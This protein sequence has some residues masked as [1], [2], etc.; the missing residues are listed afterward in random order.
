MVILHNDK[1]IK[2]T[3]ANIIDIFVYNNLD[4]IVQ[5]YDHFGFLIYNITIQFTGNIYPL[6]EIKFDTMNEFNLFDN[7]KIPIA[8][9]NNAIG[10]NC[11]ISIDHVQYQI[12]IY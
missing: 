8:K 5:S 3:K 6:P 12:S 10:Y 7:D 11:S 2:I 9:I 1:V 4:L